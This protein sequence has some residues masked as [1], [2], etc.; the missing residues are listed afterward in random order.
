MWSVGDP[1]L[2]ASGDTAGAAGVTLPHAEKLQMAPPDT[3]LLVFLERLL[4]H[5]VHMAKLDPVI[6]VATVNT[7]LLKMNRWLILP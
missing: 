1:K 3:A 7:L 5:L 2:S 6:G 4:M